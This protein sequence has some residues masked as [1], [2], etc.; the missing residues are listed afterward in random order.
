MMVNQLR[1][2]WTWVTVSG[3]LPSRYLCWLIICEPLHKYGSQCHRGIVP[4]FP[5]N[6]TFSAYQRNEAHR[7]V[8][9]MYFVPT[10]ASVH[11]DSKASTKAC[12]CWWRWKTWTD[13]LWNEWCELSALL[14]FR[15]SGSSFLNPDPPYLYAFHDGPKSGTVPLHSSLNSDSTIL[16]TTWH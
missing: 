14:A 8:F 9:L 11:P 2:L 15:Y 13:D 7:E 12:M 3:S 6:Y 10:L 16:S 5:C 4:L 1:L